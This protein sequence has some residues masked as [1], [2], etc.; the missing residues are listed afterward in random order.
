M[1]GQSTEN[2]IAARIDQAA[3][4]IADAVQRRDDRHQHLRHE[5]TLAMRD[6]DRLIASVASGDPTAQPHG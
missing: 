3:R 2:G 1:D 4:R 5:A 6:L